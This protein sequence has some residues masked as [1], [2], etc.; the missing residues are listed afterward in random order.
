MNTRAIATLFAAVLAFGAVVQVF[1]P[2]KARAHDIYSGPEWKVPNN[3]AVSCCDNRDCRP[4]RAYMGEDGLWR[5]WSGARW[6]TVPAERVLPTDLAKD[7]RNHLCSSLDDF[8]FCFSPAQ[9]KS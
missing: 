5:A 7:G 3:P 4:T 9:P 8:V 6:L 2:L 1:L